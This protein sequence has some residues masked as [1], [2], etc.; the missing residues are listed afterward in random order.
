MI[1]I[2]TPVWLYVYCFVRADKY[3]RKRK[4]RGAVI[5]CERKRFESDVVNLSSHGVRTSRSSGGPT[6]T[7]ATWREVVKRLG[8]GAQSA[9]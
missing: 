1:V 5:Q 4:K 7:L 8:K 9:T 3:H 2:S 6:R